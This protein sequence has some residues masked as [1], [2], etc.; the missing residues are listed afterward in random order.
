MEGV[1]AAADVEEPATRQDGTLL[2]SETSSGHDVAYCSDV[3]AAAAA[4]EVGAAAPETLQ[5]NPQQRGDS[6]ALDSVPSPSLIASTEQLQDELQPSATAE[7]LPAQ[8]QASTST[9]Q[10]TSAP[11]V[12]DGPCAHSRAGSDT[13]SETLPSS[14][15]QFASR[16]S[17]SSH[18]SRSSSQST[19][20][21]ALAAANTAEQGETAAQ[22][23]NALMH[24]LSSSASK[25]T[26]LHV[27]DD[28]TLAI[29]AGCAVLFLQLPSMQQRFLLGRD[30]GGVAAVAVHPSRKLFLVAEKCRSRPPNM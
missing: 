16:L 2:Q 10:E 7:E 12:Q 24:V 3:I 22:I 26:N 20:A 1:T 9:Q 30:G 29:A 15:V 8:R 23:S 21:S 4:S 5:D 17:S 6:A 11:L 13:G 27:L 28:G 18:V 25:R 19:R 14:K